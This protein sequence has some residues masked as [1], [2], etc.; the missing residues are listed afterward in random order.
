MHPRETGR[1]RTTDPANEPVTV[2]ECRTHLREDLIGQ[3]SWIET[4]ISAARELIEDLTWRALITQVWDIYYDDFPIGGEPLELPLPPLQSVDQVDYVDSDGNTQTLAA[5]KYQVNEF[6]EPA[7]L[8]AA[9]NETWPEVR[10]ETVK[11]V[12]VTITAGYGDDASDVPKKYKQAHYFLIGHWYANRE[13]VAIGTITNEIEQ[14]LMSLLNVD[15]A[16]AMIG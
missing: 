5:S 6:A 10:D 13:S 4:A 16:R 2:G 11:A 3:D 7:I 15:H 12:T 1:N 14:T 9:Y 8:R